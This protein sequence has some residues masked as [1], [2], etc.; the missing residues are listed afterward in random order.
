MVKSAGVS[1]DP[2]TFF[3]LYKP[4]KPSPMR[5]RCRGFAVTDEVI[6]ENNGFAETDD[7]YKPLVPS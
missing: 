2:G 5:G 3:G 4:V 6:A 7:L 1:N